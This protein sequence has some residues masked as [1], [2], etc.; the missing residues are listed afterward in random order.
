MTDT[1]AAYIAGLFDGEGCVSYKQYMRQ[2]P[3]NKKP[4]PTWQIKLEIAMTEKSILVW[5]CEVLGV[6]TVTEKKYKTKYALGWKKQWRWRCSH[7]DAFFVCRLIFPFTHV[8]M[9][10]VQK[11]LQ[12]YAHIKMNDNVVDLKEY[13]EFMSLE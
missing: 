10:G 6:G 3:H 1:E 13:K 12:H 4:Y 9:E 8:K 5:L 2:R 7:R 11:I